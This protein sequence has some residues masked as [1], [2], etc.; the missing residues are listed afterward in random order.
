MTDSTVVCVE[1]PDGDLLLRGLDL[2]GHRLFVLVDV[3]A[4]DTEAIVAAALVR[5]STGEAAVV[6]LM[7]RPDEPSSTRRL[8]DEIELAACRHGFR[9][10]VSDR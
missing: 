8:E 9:L 2:V 10:E 4:P 1:A 5:W 3:A 6:A 7:A